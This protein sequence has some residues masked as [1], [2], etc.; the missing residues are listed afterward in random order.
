MK[1]KPTV[2]L[3]NAC[4]AVL[5][6]SPLA[7]QAQT[8]SKGN[9]N[10]HGLS[11]DLSAI[12][13][14]NLSTGKIGNISGSAPAPYT[15]SN[16]AVPI[17]VNQS[18]LGLLT[19]ASISGAITNTAASTVNGT[20][21]SKTTSASSSVANLNLSVADTLLLPALISLSSTQAITSSVTVSGAP[22][23]MTSTSQVS[24]AG[25]TLRVLNVP[26]TLPSNLTAVPPNTGLVIDVPGAAGVTV[27]LNETKTTGSAAGGYHTSTNAI[28]IKLNAVDLGLLNVLNGDIVIG[29]AEAGQGT[30]PDGDGIVGGLDGDS[31]GDGI[32]DALE[33]ANASNN[34]DS[35]GDGVPDHLDLDSDNDGIND[36]IEA[37]GKDANGDGKQDASGDANPDEDGDGIVDSVDPDDNVLGGG[38]GVALV[39]LNS[40]G[41][42]KPNYLD[43]DS[44]N[45][46]FSD[47]YESGQSPVNDLTGVLPPADSDGD[48]IPNAADNFVGFGDGPGGIPLPDS[49]GD[50]TPNSAETDSNNDG[51]PDIASG[52]Y[53]SLDTNGDGRIDNATDTDG[54][55]IANIVDTQPGI[56]G[57]LP[58]PT[59][60]QDGDG[61]PDGE[62]GGGL[63]D[64][65]G[66]GVPDNRDGDSD[67]DGIPDVLETA[68]DSDG[69]GIPN[70]RDLDSDGDGINDVIEAGGTDANGDGRQDA[71]GDANADED[72]DG[73][74]DSVDADDNVLGGGKGTPLS[75]PDT[76]G[77]GVRNFLDL[78]SDNDTISDLYESR[79]G[80]TDANND[81]IADGADPDKDGIAASADGLPGAY[82]DANSPPLADDDG[83]G[84]PNYI[85]PDSDGNGIPD[86]VE[87]GNGDLDGNGDG[88]VDDT[89]DTD[90]DGIPD[91]VDDNDTVPGGLGSDLIT[92]EQWKNG[93]FTAPANT[94]PAISGPNADPDGDGFTNAEEFVFGKDP[95]DPNSKPV[96]SPAPGGVPFT[97][98]VTKNPNAD[99]SVIA[100]ASRDLV[101]WYVTPNILTLTYGPGTAIKAS[102]N[103]APGT[104]GQT[105]KGFIRFRVVIP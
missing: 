83:D 40:D 51:V 38:K 4:I 69:D 22:G 63:V 50:G 68:A 54:D 14:L 100:E 103:N 20:A 11:V 37:G 42:G 92:Y 105:D 34:G 98:G 70:F 6:A 80:V 73:I 26:I 19:V 66:D 77:D 90:G 7:T 25:L 13:V 31:D 62:E 93:E 2:R 12:S 30:D 39:P 5:I 78:D 29:H 88:K 52:P 84:I 89:T 44:D 85:D 72:G 43:L 18:V 10:A 48:G 71:S 76:D 15:Q 82:G 57:G 74:V 95:E 56:F 53:A 58:A 45:D 65:D 17:N 59:A 86:I 1:T 8:I 99:A 94:N 81:G 101:S 49:D 79:S 97:V 24:L 36:V 23:A 104:I 55:G 47:L 27:L 3:R 91:N 61:I 35:D 96:F 41:S 33:I 21:G 46:G 60:D 102:V 28:R 9:S 32:P 64:T 16:T 87:V 75:P 67:G